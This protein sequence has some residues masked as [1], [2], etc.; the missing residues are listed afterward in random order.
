MPQGSEIGSAYLTIKA[1]PDASFANE[2]GE[3]GTDAGNMFSGKFGVVMGKLP[4]IIAGL[5]IGAAIGKE[6]FDVGATFDKMT[7]AI[8]IG[9]GAS[10]E[11]LDSLVASAKTIGTSV[12][13]DFEKVG[14][15]VQNLNTR[16]GITGDDLEALGERVIEA[17]NLLGSELDL[18]KLTGAFNAFGVSN[19]EAAEKLDYLFNVG[20]NTGIEMNSLMGI[21]ESAAPTMQMLGFSFEETANMAALLDKAG[22]DASGTMSKMNKALVELAQP[23]ESAANAYQRLIEEMGAYLE[24]GDEAAA[25]DIAGK[26]FGTRGA[27]QFVGALK[28]GA[29]SMDEIKNAALGAGD[30]IMGTMEQTRSFDESLQ[31]LKNT[32]MVA[33]EPVASAVF[34]GISDAV[35]NVT[36]FVQENQEAFDALGAVLGTVA[37]ILGT[38]VGGAFNVVG[39]I[40]VGIGSAVKGLADGFKSFADTVKGAFDTVVNIVTGAID[41]IKSI[42]SFKFELPH[43]PLPHFAVNPPGW[44]LGDLLK[45][46]LPSLGIEWY[47]K[48]GIVD[49]A[50]LIGAGEAGP[51]AIVPLT[52]P[53]IAPFADAVASRVGRSSIYIENM[54]VEADDVD[55]LILSINRRLA[56]LGAM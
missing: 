9:T 27:A 16:L 34:Q 19:D 25:L 30:G 4:G 51:E 46:Q 6:L 15:V 53:N 21:M 12:P 1:Q 10:G 35:A 29:L 48:G 39:Q 18:D 7:D 33:I 23:G 47:A 32:L 14:D 45:G 54:N 3:M 50:T 24:K 37:N 28:S 41:T 2:I 22:M 43:I 49:G 55:E 31:I 13:T 36:A 8:V 42:F 52:A 56:E 5:G 40:I 44:Q 20:Q 38:V 17:G 26:V 11:A